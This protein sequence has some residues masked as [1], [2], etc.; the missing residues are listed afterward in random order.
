[1]FRPI[2]EHVAALAPRREVGRRVVGCVVVS[3][4]G[5]QHDTGSPDSRKHVV[6][7]DGKTDDPA[8]T[9]TPGLGLVVPP[10][11]IREAEHPLPVRA[12]ASLASALGAAEA[13]R[14]RQLAPIDRIEEP[15]FSADRH[16]GTRGNGYAPAYARPPKLSSDLYG[17]PALIA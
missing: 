4:R 10:S 5:G 17:L 16:R 1:M 13:D 14:G 6:G 8:G 2:V 15:M 12:P 9:I 3:V 7:A 11:A